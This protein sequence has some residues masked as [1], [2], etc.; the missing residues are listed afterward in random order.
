M[1]SFLSLIR[2]IT[3]IAV[4]LIFTTNILAQNK[5]R[6]RIGES[7][8]ILLPDDFKI[9]KKHQEPYSLNRTQTFHNQIA[10][11]KSSETSE[12]RL[13]SLVYFYWDNITGQLAENMKYD[14]FY[15][16][17]N[18]IIKIINYW[19]MYDNQRSNAFI[20]EYIYDS[21]NRNINILYLNWDRDDSLWKI[22]EKTDYTYDANN[23]LLQESHY[24][25]IMTEN[26]WSEYWKYEY[27]YNTDDK[28]IQK[29]NYNWYNS[30]DQW[31]AHRIVEY[32]YDANGNN[33]ENRYFHL[34]DSISQWVL[35]YKNVFSF[36]SNNDK[37]LEVGWIR[38][39]TLSSWYEYS[40]YE[41][42]YEYKANRKTMQ[43]I[44]YQ[45]HETSGQLDEMWKLKYSFDEMGNLIRR[46]HY[47]WNK[48]INQWYVHR[49]YEFAYDDSV[50]ISNVIIPFQNYSYEKFIIKNLLASV[51]AYDWNELYDG[52]R[53]VHKNS[54]YYSKP[55]TYLGIDE[56]NSVEL[57]VY[58]NPVSEYLSLNNL[59]NH[60]YITFKLFDI[61]GS[62]VL[63]KKINPNQKINLK[64]IKKGMYIYTL[65]ME[66]N[67]W[68]GK[69]IK[70]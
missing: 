36:N 45:W 43:E 66:G 52:W 10:S 42:V 7:K 19:T 3:F 30:S 38:D 48:I 61:H 41:Y 9:V 5:P 26:R 51:E 46:T 49:K 2:L 8:N 1:D 50:P 23:N 63:A 40:K 20:Q 53:I 29:V 24:R 17:N 33:S 11:F 39:D 14:Y 13:D 18:N 65:T 60:K 54:L 15:D 34:D 70:N 37:I 16:A 56:H 64:H 44:Y 69:I 68:S 21:I 35:N 4:S 28:M 58:P 55:N 32:N 25:W 27:T 62:L 57:C 47:N 6:K 67:S 59:G 12:Q 31:F 22:S